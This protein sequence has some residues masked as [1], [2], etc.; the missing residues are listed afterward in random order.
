M[1]RECM[2]MR[3]RRLDRIVTRLYDDALRPFGLKSTQLSV[4]IGIGVA[5]TLQ[6]SHLGQALA[7]E[8]ST[9]SR[10][11]ARLVERG[12]VTSEAAEDGRG[13]LL[14]LTR[15]GASLLDEA[16][17]AWKTAQRSVRAIIGDEAGD[18]LTNMNV[19]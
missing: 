19:S 3:A 10:N 2:A 7:M 13:Q 11:V 5:G 9:V 12:W 16:H 18:A 15:S 6:P 8:K 4:L 17:N 1:A 14:S